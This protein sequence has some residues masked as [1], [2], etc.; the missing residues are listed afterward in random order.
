MSIEKEL[1]LLKYQVYL[2]KKMVVSEDHPFFMY[3]LDHN[4][5][6]KQVK[7]ICKVLNVFSHR[8]SDDTDQ[9]SIDYHQHVSD[10]DNQ[11]YE[12]FSISETELLKEEKPSIKE[13]ELLKEKIFSDSINSKYLLL[14]L[15]G[16]YIQPKVCEYLLEELEASL[17]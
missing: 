14:S 9:N 17:D 1:E 12:N 2:L 5:D 13:F 8:L 11:L 4:L 3:A 6:E 7:M 15:K 10:E 16:Q